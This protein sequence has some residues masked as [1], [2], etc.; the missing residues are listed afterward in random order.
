LKTKTFSLEKVFTIDYGGVKVIVGVAA[1]GAVV[2]VAPAPTVLVAAAPPPTT[3]W[4]YTS[5]P[6]N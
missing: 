5:S 4:T 3:T 2:D 6:K 1:G